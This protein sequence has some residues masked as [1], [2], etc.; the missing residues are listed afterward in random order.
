MRSGRSGAQHGRY[1]ALHHAAHAEQG[2]A[3][4]EHRAHFS[5]SMGLSSIALPAPGPGV[6]LRAVIGVKRIAT[7]S[8][9][10]GAHVPGIGVFGR[11]AITIQL[12]A[13]RL[14]PLVDQR[15]PGRAAAAHHGVG[16]NE[17]HRAVVFG[18]REIERDVAVLADGIEHFEA[19]LGRNDH[20]QPA[21][22]M[23]RRQPRHTT[24][25]PEFVQPPTWWATPAESSW[26]M[27][28][29]SAIWSSYRFL[30]YSPCAQLA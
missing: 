11:N 25:R 8:F 29:V 1:H 3:V 23:L 27:S 6:W 7:R 13:E 5:N 14:V 19:G 28:S 20:Q 10:V 17:T 21:G 9:V 30:K 22:F 18:Q 15:S 12:R 24:G 4:V 26:I 16:T 2:Q